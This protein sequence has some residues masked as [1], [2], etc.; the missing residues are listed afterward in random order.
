MLKRALTFS[1]LIFSLQAYAHCPAS[2]KP[3][4]LCLMLDQNVLYIYD[5]KSDHN[6]PYVDLKSALIETIQ[7]NGKLIKFNKAA[8]GVYKLESL[9]KLKSLEIEMVSGKEKLK[10]K[11]KAEN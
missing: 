3:E 6:G 10:L 2:F 8:R 11:I 9:E 1:A 7:S 4:S 5:H